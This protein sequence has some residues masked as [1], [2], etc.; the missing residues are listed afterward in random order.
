MPRS[1]LGNVAHTAETD[2]TIPRWDEARNLAPIIPITTGRDELPLMPFESSL[3]ASGE[4]SELSRELGIAIAGLGT[5]RSSDRARLARLALPL[6]ETSLTSRPDDPIAWQAKIIALTLRN[7]TEDVLA[8]AR[9]ALAVAPQNERSLAL[10]IPLLATGQRDEAIAC[11][12]RLLAVNPMASEYQIVLAKLLAQNKDWAGSAEAC[13]AALGLDPL[14]QT[15]RWILI[16]SGIE[17]GDQARARAEVETY[18]RFDPPAGERQTLLQWI[19][20]T[21]SSGTAP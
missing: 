10:A 16:R 13:R 5:E 4:E 15:A 7:R 2:H 1:A 12:R 8:A 14:N 18:L 9:S 17:T 21:D 11:A 3:P 6:L 19:G 20:R